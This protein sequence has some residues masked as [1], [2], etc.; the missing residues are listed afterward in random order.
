M[1]HAP[2]RSSPIRFRIALIGFGSLGQAIAAELAAGRLRG[3]G[4][5]GALL[6]AGQQTDAV[7]QVWHDVEALIAA[8][9]DLV[10]EAAGHGALQAHGR[11]CLQA[12]LDL[13]AAS[14]GALLD[15]VLHGQL[16]E[17][18]HEGGSLLHVPSGAL[19]GLDYLRAARRTGPIWV[20]YQGRKPVLAWR[21]TAAETL[22]D[23]GRIESA[24]AFFRGS[25]RD[26]ARLF[27]Q[28][29]NVVAA[30]A[31]AVGDADA[32]S[33]ELIADPQSTR[34]SH[35]VSAEGDAGIFRLSVENLP[36]PGNPKTSRVTAYS[37]VDE[38][39]MHFGLGA[40]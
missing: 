11:A 28:N 13:V 15:P 23:L 5:L 2:G 22:V 34:N 8:G 24:T 37:I 18:A 32:V 27:P 25:A 21:G 14:V 38:I 39:A 31:L 20:H 17:A 9:P 12:G 4:I 40:A 33:V 19:G 30:L 10:V 3:V 6:P 29:A 26:A 16:K 36:M 7:P 1:T 35:H